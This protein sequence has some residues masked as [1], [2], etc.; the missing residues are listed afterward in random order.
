VIIGAGMAGIAVAHTFKQAGFD[1]FSGA[2]R[3]AGGRYLPPF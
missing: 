1:N 2:R 3:A